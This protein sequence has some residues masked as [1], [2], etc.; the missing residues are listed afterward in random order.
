VRSVIRLASMTVPC[1]AKASW[2]SFSVV[3]KERFPTNSLLFICDVF[4]AGFREC[5]R[6]PGL[7]SSLNRVQLKIYHALKVTSYLT[8][9]YIPFF[10][11]L[12]QALFSR[13]SLFLFAF[14]RRSIP[15]H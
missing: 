10:Y 12:W 7:E 3:L 14:Q 13:T 4:N 5:S 1:A 9:H 15:R 2:R 6:P 8:K 11:R